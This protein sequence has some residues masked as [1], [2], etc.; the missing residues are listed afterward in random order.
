MPRHAK[1]T[2][3]QL[4]D[5]H[6]KQ[7][8]ALLCDLPSRVIARRFLNACGLGKDK[9]H[10][11]EV[12]MQMQGET[13]ACALWSVAYAPEQSLFASN[14]ITERAGMKRWNCPSQACL[15]PDFPEVPPDDWT[16]DRHVLQQF[17]AVQCHALFPGE[18]I[19]CESG[20]R[21]TLPPLP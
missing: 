17:S 10:D 1:L 11:V 7:I 19:P 16:P 3:A 5:S 20:E 12:R 18:K 15:I 8:D 2:I 4:A 6:R 14:I 9:I 21:F 13:V